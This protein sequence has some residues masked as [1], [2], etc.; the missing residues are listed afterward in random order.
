MKA[1][2]KNGKE[3]KIRKL[4]LVDSKFDSVIISVTK[5]CLYLFGNKIKPWLEQ[6]KERKIQELKRLKNLKKQ[7]IADKIKKL[8]GYCCIFYTSSLSYERNIMSFLYL[9]AQL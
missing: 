8:K 4:K 3:D 9:A 5:Y 6:E 2:L 1:E 7:E